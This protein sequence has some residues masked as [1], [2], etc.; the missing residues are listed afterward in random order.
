MNYKAI[1]TVVLALAVTTGALAKSG[2]NPDIGDP[3]K[4]NIGI[5]T[6]VDIGAA[7]PWPP[8]KTLGGENKMSATPKLNL[9]L[10]L[11]TTV[12]F[13][14]HWSITAEGTYKTVSLDATMRTD[15]Q[16]IT[17]VKPA[18]E[19][20]VI[21][22]FEGTANASMS[23]TMVEVPVF[24]RYT[25]KS[26][27]NRILF[28]GYY[29]FV[30]DGKFVTTP[31]KGM[32]YP[33]DGTGHRDETKGDE[34]TPE[35]KYTQNFSQYLDNWD[36]G[37][38]LGYERRILKRLTLSGRL[39]MGFKDIFQPDHHYLDYDM[40]NIRGSFVLSYQIFKK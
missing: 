13:N 31:Q 33:D 4:F 34:I 36:A 2:K 25:F 7:I 12:G 24:L 19:Q 6:G 5:H 16:K 15:N 20:D 1:L 38:I 27:N 29:S 40:L 18:P 8:G 10:G 30:L 3:T 21:K 35:T 11:S 9:A 17:E 37:V 28:G 23:F 32:L 22:Y 39:M 26:G 14:K